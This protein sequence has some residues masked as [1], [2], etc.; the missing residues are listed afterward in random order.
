MSTQHW[1][2]SQLVS[3]WKSKELRRLQRS[4]GSATPTHATPYH[5]HHTHP[6]GAVSHTLLLSFSHVPL[7]SWK[8]PVCPL[9]SFLHLKPL[10]VLKPLSTVGSCYSLLTT[11]GPLSPATLK[12]REPLPFL[13]TGR[14]TSSNLH[15]K[16]ANSSQQPT[17][18]RRTVAPACSLNLN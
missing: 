14:S 2:V 15:H 11:L 17:Q 1:P 6:S 13:A 5:H 3:T 7:I 16:N 10:H 8:V 12:D 18:P 4:S 9:L